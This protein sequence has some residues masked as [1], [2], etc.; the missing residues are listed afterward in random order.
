M[1]QFLNSIVIAI[2]LTFASYAFGMHVGWITSINWI[3]AFAVFTSYSC[4][5]LCV[6]Q[7]RW[8]YPIGAVSTAAW[9]ILFWTQGMYALSMF[10]LYLV[11][12]LAY[13]YIRWGKDEVTR[14][15]TD[16]S[17]KQWGLYSLFGVGVTIL[18]LTVVGF[19][20]IYDGSGFIGSIKSLSAIDV[21]LAAMS[22][23]AQLLLDNKKSSNWIVWIIVNTISIPYFFVS[24]LPV[25][26]L[27]YVLFLAN[28]VWGYF[29]WRRSIPKFEMIKV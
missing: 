2:A 4:T 29:M 9:S 24:G 12:S 22:G 10:N 19:V 5:F 13:G 6:L 26:A 11:F 16:T 17:L 28:A 7:T 15:V 3:E 25:T 20:G 1:T 18:F 21:L 27:Q 23:V 14:P 8:N